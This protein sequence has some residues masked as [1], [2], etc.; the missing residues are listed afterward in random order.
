MLRLNVGCG[1][2]DAGGE[3]CRCFVVTVMVDS[4][5]GDGNGGAVL[6]MLIVM[7]MMMVVVSMVVVDA[8]DGGDDGGDVGNEMLVIVFNVNGGDAGET[9]KLRVVVVRCG[10][11]RDGGESGGIGQLQKYEFSAFFYDWKNLFVVDL[12]FDNTT[13]AAFKQI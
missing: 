4:V 7:V 10:V 3:L 8:S 11:H 6:V 13:N 9:V 1:V 2:C 12:H 5:G